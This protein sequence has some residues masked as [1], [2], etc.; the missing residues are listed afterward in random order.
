MI[1]KD[2]EFTGLGGPRLYWQAWLP[3]EPARAVVVVAHGYAEHGGRYANL[4]E[5]LVSRGSAVYALD[6]RGSGRSQGPRGHVGRFSE[7]V[8]DLHAFRVRVDAEMRDRPLF[9]LGHS[10]GGL[11][12]V[13]YLLAYGQGIAGA[14]LSSPALGLVD[15]PSR[16]L[17]WIARVLS[18]VAPRASFAG[19]VNPELLSH[20]PSVAERYA[21]DPL[22]HRRATAR[23]FV[24]FQK[25][26]RGAH[27]RAP[28]IHLPILILQAGD[29]RL[30]DPRAT[31]SFAERVG[32][33]SKEV[34]F[35]PG[36]YHEIF[37]ETDRDRVFDDLERWLERQLALPA[38][39]SR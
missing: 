15:P 12:A 7:F 34:R 17:R 29:D 33:A 31:H 4:A 8:S 25:A 27:E 28:E 36:L 20:E 3:D 1:H 23:F 14:V 10:M 16:A 32:S 24:E 21:A 19:N 26:M 30:V 35:Y 38:E 37:N 22:V 39:E 5:R 9:L 13:H 2:G 6:H 18:V 11:I